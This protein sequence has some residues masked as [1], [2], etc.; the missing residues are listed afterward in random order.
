MVGYAVRVDEERGMT[1]WR[2]VV[3][4]C[5]VGDFELEDATGRILVRA[6]VSD[7]ELETGEARGKGGP[8]RAVPRRIISLLHRHGRPATGVLFA[9]AFRWRERVLEE[10]ARVRVRGWAAR[11]EVGREAS[12]PLVGDYR[13]LPS[14]LA[15]IGGGSRPLQV[16]ADD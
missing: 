13:E 2:P 14:R 7:V 15:V 16:A 11:A 8:F 10:G 12:F 3:E 1:A 6:S 4:Q 5:R 9:R